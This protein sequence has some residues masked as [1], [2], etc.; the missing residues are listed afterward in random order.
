MSRTKVVVS[1]VAEAEPGLWSN[2]IRKNTEV[3]RAR[4]KFFSGDVPASTLVEVRSLAGRETLV[5]IEA[6]AHFGG[7]VGLGV[8]SREGAEAGE[9][10]DHR[11][12]P[13]RRGRDREGRACVESARR[14]L[15]DGDH[16]RALGVAQV[17]G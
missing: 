13:A 4:R 15:H 14:V 3:R 2:G 6:V 1:N 16:P 9:P 10:G 11:G 7:E 12:H 17:P 5:E 8:P